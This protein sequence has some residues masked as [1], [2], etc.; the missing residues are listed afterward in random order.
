MLRHVARD[1]IGLA[2]LLI[3]VTSLTVWSDVLIAA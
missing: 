3:F 1:T 2:A